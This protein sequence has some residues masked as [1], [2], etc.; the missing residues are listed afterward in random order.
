MVNELKQYIAGESVQALTSDTRAQLALSLLA[1]VPSCVESIAANL[2][3]SLSCVYSSPYASEAGKINACML[4]QVN[5]KLVQPEQILDDLMAWCLQLIQHPEEDLSS[6]ALFA[7]LGATKALACTV[8]PGYLA[9]KV[10]KLRETTTEWLQSDDSFHFSRAILLLEV[11]VEICESEA[12]WS[13]D[14]LQLLLDKEFMLQ[15]ER[16]DGEASAILKR[17]AQAAFWV[18]IDKLLQVMSD[19][20]VK[21]AS[22]V[23]CAA[24]DGTV[25]CHHSALLWCYRILGAGLTMLNGALPEGMEPPQLVQA[26]ESG[27][28]VSDARTPSLILTFCASIFQECCFRSEEMRE[29]VL[30]PLWNS[31]LDAN[32]HVIATQVFGSTFWNHPELAD[33]FYEEAIEH[34]TTIDKAVITSTALMEFVKPETWMRGDDTL[35]HVHGRFTHPLAVSRSYVLA[36]IEERATESWCEKYLRAAIARFQQAPMNAGQYNHAY[37][38]QFLQ[39]FRVM[40]S[41]PAAVRRISDPSISAELCTS[42]LTLLTDDDRLAYYHR[43]YLELAITCL[44]VQS[45]DTCLPLLSESL[46]DLAC[47]R[48]TSVTSK[49]IVAAL[50]VNEMNRQD[51]AWPGLHDFH[52]ELAVKTIPWATRPRVMTRSLAHWVIRR[53][54]SSLKDWNDAAQTL[55]RET[56]ALNTLAQELL[57]NILADFMPLKAATFK[58]HCDEQQFNATGDQI[59]MA[60]SVRILRDFENN[61][62]EN[63]NKSTKPVAYRIITQDETRKHFEETGQDATDA[64]ALNI[65]EKINPNAWQELLALTQVGDV[66]LSF[67]R[68]LLRQPQTARRRAGAD[69]LVVVCTLLEHNLPSIAAL[70]RTCEVLGVA[71]IVVHSLD[72]LKLD[73]FKAVTL[74]AGLWMPFQAVT[75]LE[76]PGFLAQHKAQGSSLVGL[77][78]ADPLLPPLAE[79]QYAKNAVLVVADEPTGMDAAVAELLDA[80]VSLPSLGKS[81][82]VLPHIA[83]AI[84]IWEFVLQRRLR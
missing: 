18:C 64:A 1:D 71:K 47:S 83:G 79:H 52:R 78:Q 62:F 46:G 38:P 48:N 15:V 61:F 65:Q 13:R 32:A 84:G 42:L 11:L 34:L 37:S 39:K 36:F 5:A 51:P 20:D 2:Q 16:K 55:V 8:E 41:I 67:P 63:V 54:S 24:L 30:R 43:C 33:G 45:P 74:S 10:V 6:R 31:L 58:Y 40:Q 28:E 59:L 66:A 14:Q 60:T 81:P 19:T 76:L 70:V 17:R 49:L 73:T 80:N 75:R 26:L 82:S 72:I 44:M 12:K 56:E 77:H 27:L 25:K 23:T 4:V 68:S 22:K 57:D 9:P 7:A 53:C 29:Q 50:V 21:L 3:D 35:L 69:G